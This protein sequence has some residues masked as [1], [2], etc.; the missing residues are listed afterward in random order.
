MGSSA[1]PALKG[2]KPSTT[3]MY[4]LPKMMSPFMLNCIAN[5]MNA[6]T[7]MPAS[8]SRRMFSSGVG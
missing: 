6:F 5:R 4:A 2:S 7:R 8:P 1:M 3:C